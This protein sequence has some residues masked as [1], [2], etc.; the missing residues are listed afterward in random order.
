MADAT[1]TV[2]PP[3]LW[4]KVAYGFGT[5]AYGVKDHGFNYFLLIFYSQVLGVDARM[6]GL[7][8]TLA[9]VLDAISDPIVGYWSDNLRSRWG[10]R[11]PFMYASAI[12]V[13]ATYYLLW[14]PPVGWSNT[15]LFW[16][17]LALSVLIRTFITFFETPSSA[18]APE[19]TDDYDQRSSLLSFRSFFGWTGGNVM[20]VLMFMV[21]FPAFATATIKNGQFNRDAYAV[22]GMIASALIFLAV[23]V[24]SLGT[25]S[26]IAHLKDPPPKRAMSLG[27]VFREIFETLA[28]RSFVSLFLAFMLGAVATGLSAALAFYFTT[29]YWEFTPRQVGWVTISIFMS[30]VIGGTMAPI[31]TRTIGKKRGAMIIGLIAFLGSPTPIVLRLLGLLPA[32]GTPELFWIVLLTSMF[33]TGLIICFQILQASMLADL[34]EQAELK[35][36]RR[37]EGIFFAASTFIRKTVQ[38]LGVI[39]AGFVLALAQFPAGVSPSEVPAEALWRLGAFYA[40][41]ILALWLGMLAVMSTYKLSR[42]DHEEN[43]R[44]L[45]VARATPGEPAGAGLT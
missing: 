26:R 31:V 15:A 5:V 41:T 35:T 1:L 7:A 22:Y 21:L 23:M 29:Y 28:N 19:L 4:T 38:G 24:S 27:L 40:P 11:H 45:A 42:A 14:N 8:I 33:D 34:V 13:A 36:G 2:P 12:P 18:L 25:H 10:R 9:L 3:S 20:S 39:T 17:V 16:Y 37:S 44:K 6:V 43:L 32:N 30:A